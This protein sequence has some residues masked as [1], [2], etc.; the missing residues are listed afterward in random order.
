MKKLIVIAAI[1][2]SGSGAFAQNE[3][4]QAEEF[5]QKGIAAEKVG[6]PATAIA[7]YNA[8]LQIFPGHANARFKLGQVKLNAVAIKAAATENKIG[9]VLIPKYKLDGDTVQNAIQA[10]SLG[11]D[12]A[13]EGKIAPNFII[14][15]PQ[16]KLAEVKI[17][18]QL[19]N[20]PVKAILEYIHAQAATR[21][22]YDEH[23]VVIMPR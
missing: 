21:A 7:A 9:A 14:E 5:Y 19:K 10:L 15:D 4:Q 1:A 8:A 11:I 17:S 16:G 2:L 13:T 12:K 22:R 6:D 20:V 3:A 18:L 23:A